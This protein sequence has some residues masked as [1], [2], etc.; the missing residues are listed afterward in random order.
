L[1]AEPNVIRRIAIYILI[2]LALF[3][4][5]VGWLGRWHAGLK[6]RG[7]M[8]ADLL[9]AL[10]EPAEAETFTHRGELYLVVYGEAEML[11]RFPSGPP[12]YAFDGTGRLVA[13]SADIGDDP[14]FLGN[15]SA[16]DRRRLT[17]AEVRTWPGA[18]P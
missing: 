11:P 17:P 13:W 14:W 2:I 10:P 12:A 5:W 16:V 18:V 7:P 9:V 15:A 3:A 1:T 4:A 8:L 6:P